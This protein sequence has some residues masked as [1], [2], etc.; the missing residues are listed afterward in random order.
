MILAL[1]DLGGP[2]AYVSAVREVYK[3]LR[4]SDNP[5]MPA[6]PAPAADAVRIA[7]M[8]TGIDFVRFPELAL[9]LGSGKNGQIASAD[10]AD[11]DLT[12]FLVDNDRFHHGTGTTASV[13]T[14]MAHYAPETLIERVRKRCSRP[15][16]RLNMP[17]R[18]LLA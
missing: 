12:P 4:D 15:L 16:S 17:P 2:A 13:L 11:S 14:I 8:D 3:Q 6:H 5:A 1:A 10:F 9:F 18:P 7:V